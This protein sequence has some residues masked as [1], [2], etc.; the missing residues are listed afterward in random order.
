MI[1]YSSS[2]NDILLIFQ[3]SPPDDDMSM[4]MSPSNLM[5]SMGPAGMSQM[6]QT[7]SQDMAKASKGP[8]SKPSAQ[9]KVW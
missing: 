4:F 7:P 8:K 9:P 5:S 2:K 1:S 6:S 3:Y